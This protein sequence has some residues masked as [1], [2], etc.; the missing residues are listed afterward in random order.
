MSPLSNIKRSESREKISRLL[1]EAGDVILLERAAAILDLS[2]V[3]TAKTLARWCQQGWLTRVKHGMYA[4]V[5]IEAIDTNQAL[6]DAWVFIPALFKQ[7]YI[8]GWSAAEHWDLTE[9]IFNDL[10]VFTADPVAKRHQNIHT[11]SL[12]VA[13]RAAESHFGTKTVW[14]KNKKILVSDPSKTIV[15]ILATPWAGGGIQHVIDCFRAYCRHELYQEKTLI[16]YAVR[17]DNGAVFK[18]LG[19]LASQILGEDHP[20]TSIC[21]KNLTQGK[22]QIDPSH[23]GNRLITAW[24]LFVPETLTIEGGI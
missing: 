9:Q 3:A 22:V 10:C 20:V 15:D 4:P 23:K 12:M 8:A 13:H 11:V 16:D 18:R 6:E 2:P 21:S 24:Q 1:R 7:A 5:P 14:K 17:L 19:F